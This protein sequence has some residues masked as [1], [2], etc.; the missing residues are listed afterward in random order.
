MKK[1]SSL[2]LFAEDAEGLEVISSMTQDGL[3]KIANLSFQPKLRRFTIE[4][5]RFNWEFFSKKKRYFR[6]H[7]MLAVD[8][9][10]KVQ[11]RNL[12]SK[13]DDEIISLLSISFDHKEADEPEGILSLTFAKD[14]E[15][16]LLV[17]CLD[18]TLIDSDT[19]WP[20][21]KMPK[22]KDTKKA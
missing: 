6:T 22:H 4:M 14:I 12:P 3:A 15:I 1:P 8:G 20:T 2:K 18:V 7:S 21:L 11:S 13:N 19:S 17:E 16:K 10:L 9:V 5:N